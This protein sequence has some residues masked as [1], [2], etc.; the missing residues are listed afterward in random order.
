MH[1]R[2]GFAFMLPQVI[3]Q[4]NVTEVH[5]SHEMQKMQLLPLK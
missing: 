2:K 4:P 3:K 5:D 1:I